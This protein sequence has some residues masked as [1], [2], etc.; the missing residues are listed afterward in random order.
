MRGMSIQQYA[1]LSSILFAARVD[2][3]NVYD[4]TINVYNDA[5][6][7]IFNTSPTQSTIPIVIED[8]IEEENDKNNKES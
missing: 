6:H 5:I 4:D 1:A 3:N 8:K 7:G 2:I